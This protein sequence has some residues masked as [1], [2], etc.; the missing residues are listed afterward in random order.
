M[1]GDVEQLV[2]GFHDTGPLGERFENQEFGYC[3]RDVLSAPHHLVARRVHDQ[4]SALQQRRLGLFSG[5]PRRFALGELLPAKDCADPSNQQPLGEGLGNI[6]VGPH[7][8]SQCLVELVVL[9]REEN[10]GHGAEFADPPKQLHSVHV[11]HLD[12]EDAK[13]RWLVRKGFKGGRRIGI[14]TGHEAFGL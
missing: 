4:A 1:I 10:D 8:E 11:G 9:R 13:V 3:Q 12:V 2:A 14:D 5:R 7:R 6:I